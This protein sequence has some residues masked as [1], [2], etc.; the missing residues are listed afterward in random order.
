MA[1]G[2]R[3]PAPGPAR[4][5][6]PWPA[7]VLPPGFVVRGADSAQAPR[8]GSDKDPDEESPDSLPR[9]NLMEIR[10]NTPEPRRSEARPGA[11]D[12]AQT[13]G[14]AGKSEREIAASTERVEGA[15]QER[16]RG[17][18]ARRAA[19]ADEA[20]P[21]AEGP[22]RADRADRADREELARRRYA[23]RSNQ[24]QGPDRL[25]VSSQ[26]DRLAR[27]ETALRAER[28]Q[29]VS[30]ER[31]AELRSAYREGRLNTMELI[32]RSADRLLAG[33]EGE[34]AAAERQG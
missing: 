20:R 28:P 9:E 12:P 13:A 5:G 2:A 26:A 18:A 8:K 3:I 17:E 31:L 16:A 24:A 23:R 10:G 22:E 11:A 15:R 14:A 27:I 1:V 30:P 4:G 6:L 29:P 33:D 25:E 7:A 19:Q 32:V 21:R 34:I